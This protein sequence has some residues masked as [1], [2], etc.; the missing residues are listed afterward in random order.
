M[1]DESIEWHF[2]DDENEAVWA[3]KTPLQRSQQLGNSGG[4][5]STPRSATPRYAPEL[6]LGIILIYT[7]ALFLFWHHMGA[8]LDQL[9][10]E[11][12][13]LHTELVAEQQGDPTGNV[14]SGSDAQ[15]PSRFQ[16][17]TDYLHFT[18]SPA[19]SAVVQAVAAE[20]DAK[21][22]QMHAD[23][24]FSDLLPATKLNIIV[25][26]A[27]NEE[28]PF[29]D[30][31]QLVVNHPKTMAEKYK[32]SEAEALT[33]QLSIMLARHL[34]NSAINRSAIKQQWQGMVLAM[35]TYIQ[36]E[37]GYNQQWQRQDH[38][39]LHR[40]NAQGR[41]LDWTDDVIVLVPSERQ[42]GPLLQVSP[43][44]YATAD[45]LVEFMLVTYGHGKVAELLVAFTEHD[46]WET[47]TPALFQLSA[48]NFEEQWHAYLAEHYPI[49]Q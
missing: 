40:H 36:L 16:I 26:I 10:Q 4:E 47:L 29:T 7:A 3:A 5:Q 25:D 35:Q 32:I 31:Q 42:S 13:A 38:S 18:A 23:L 24:G 9:E 6:L 34:L 39:L 20:I 1:A 15:I 11:L 45:P 22:Q 17:Q 27:T 8:Q 43:T 49:P 14:G 2:F 33:T 41:S 46:S 19:T 30:D 28:R 48:A 21:F 12:E 44:A 37:H